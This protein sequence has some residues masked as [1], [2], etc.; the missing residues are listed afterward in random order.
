MTASLNKV[1]IIGNLGR[2]PEVKTVGSVMVANFSVATDEGYKD[3]SGQKVEKTEWHKVVLW[4]GLAE[5]AEKYLRKGS[6]VYV[7]GKLVT[8]SWEDQGGVTKYTT[9]IVGDRLQMLGGRRQ[10]SPPHEDAS[11][12]GEWRQRL[13][14]A[15]KSTIPEP[16]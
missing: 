10:E 6:T 8:R 5:I 7:E 4:R 3:K 11:L 16:W 9:E 15:P 13:T 1:M 12:N 2:D 14:P